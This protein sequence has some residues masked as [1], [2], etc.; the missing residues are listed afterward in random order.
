MHD[1]LL[2]RLEGVGD[3]GRVMLCIYA[4]RVECLSHR[5]I[6]FWWRSRVSASLACRDIHRVLSRK[7]A[8]FGTLML[9][10]RGGIRVHMTMIPLADLA[11]AEDLINDGLSRAAGAWPD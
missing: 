3:G 11:H 6:L 8:R 7:G 2:M 1:G 5:R 10:A 4:D 9:E